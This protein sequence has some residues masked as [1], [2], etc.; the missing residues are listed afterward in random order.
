MG[1]TRIS[2]NGRRG[3][4]LA[5]ARPPSQVV[6]GS[7]PVG[8]LINRLAATTRHELLSI[9]APLPRVMLP[10]T[11]V[12]LIAVPGE[13]AE[14]GARHEGVEVRLIDPLPFR[15]AVFDRGA[16][17]LPLDLDSFH[18]GVL[19]VRDPVVVRTLA[20]AHQVCW[21]LSGRASPLDE[22]PP[23]LQPV[24]SS[25]LDGLTD[26][27]ASMRLGMSLRTYSRRVTEILAALGTTSRF[28]AGVQAVRRG[29]A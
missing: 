1:G 10:G 3:A 15:M 18:N 2:G 5:S 19:L 8:I 27:A 9:G 23:H 26:Q 25:L 28:H 14:G 16:A 7:A 6:M 20:G 22:P 21:E 11:V 13:P 17:L 4:A 12:R 29:W 24:L